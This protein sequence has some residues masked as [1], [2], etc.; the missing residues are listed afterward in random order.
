MTGIDICKN[1]LTMIARGDVYWWGAKG[2]KCTAGLLA[3]LASSYPSVYTTSYRTKCQTDIRAGKYAEDCSGFV[4]KCYG[5]GGLGTYGIINR[6]DVKVWTEGALKNNNQGV[7][8]NGMIVWKSSHCGI[9]YNGYVLESRGRNYGTT[10]DR[11]YKASDWT[12]TLYSVNV[13]YDTEETVENYDQ[14]VSDV[15]AGKYGNG[16]KRTTALKNAG[17]TADE[18]KTIQ[19]LVN[20][21][22]SK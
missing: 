7:P 19:Q 13:D 21:K 3:R 18:I 22:L 11:K 2:E 14:V 8:K 10:R 12:Y 16:R 9:Y 1:A 4:S 17:Y 5:W 15:I 20:K 6:S